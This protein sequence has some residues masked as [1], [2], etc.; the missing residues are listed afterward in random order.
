M[1]TW[2]N[3]FVE[4]SGHISHPLWQWRGLLTLSLVLSGYQQQWIEEAIQRGPGRQAMSELVLGGRKDLTCSQTMRFWAMWL[5]SSENCL[6][7][8]IFSCN[9]IYFFVC[10]FWEREMKI[11]WATCV[12][13]ENNTPIWLISLSVEKQRTT[14]PVHNLMPPH[15]N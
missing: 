7:W 11:T 3:I 6:Y 14:G 15:F 9:I 12:F 8:V 4:P 2:K 13:N 1:L 5:L 10:L